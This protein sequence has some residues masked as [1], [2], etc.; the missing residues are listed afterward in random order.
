M[1]H[2]SDGDFD[3]YVSAMSAR[4]RTLTAQTPHVFMTDA[5]DLFEVY[6]THIAP[7]RRQHYTC[8][9]CRHFVR[10]F[11]SLVHIGPDGR[12][13]PLLWDPEAEAGELTEAVRAM[14]R[15]VASAPVTGVL[16][17]DERAWG[18]PTSPKT[19][20]KLSNSP[21]QDSGEWTHFALHDAHV[22]RPPLGKTC[23]Q[24]AAELREDYG[25]L[26]R[27]LADFDEGVVA[28]AVTLLEQDALYRS[29]KVLG[30]A[31]WLAGLHRDRKVARGPRERDNLVWLAVATAPAGFA[32]AR[33]TMIGT[34]LEDLA[35]GLAFEEVRRRFAAK[36]HPL[37]YQRPQVPPRAGN[38]A[39]A[40]RL[41]AQLKTAGALERR[42]ARL[43]DVTAL[44][45]PQAPAQPAQATPGAVFGHI[46]P[47]GSAPAAAPVRSGV[48]TMTWDKFERTVLPTAERI[49][50]RVP[51]GPASFAALV[52]AARPEA[53]PILQWDSEE[54]RCP[55]SWYLYSG[56]THASR[57][58]LR[59]DAW[60]PVTAVARGPHQ[61]RDPDAFAHHGKRA[62]LILEGCHDT[63][64]LRSGGFFPENLRSEYHGVRATLEAYAL[65]ARIAGRD[66][67]TACGLWLESGQ[68][69]GQWGHRLRVHSRGV[70]SDFVLDRWD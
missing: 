62:I 50:L 26:Q 54:H 5:G 55:V 39:Q 15:V 2:P 35:A 27:S 36:M 42:F 61:W 19:G 52:T 12:Q 9:A 44:W 30:I 38:I 59:A 11:G 51:T 14:A 43:E 56:G 4:Y 18:T 21:W 48:Q 25:V 58:G 17:C 65:S 8:N 66:E 45:R 22:T 53:P 7:E 70:V 60:V 68:G 28:Q 24:R 32:H 20:D 34:L 1:T 3:R 47:R 16:I 41:V 6:L 31:Q 67:A 23:G 29:E 64:H 63:T 69:R 33:N 40:E 10:R 37:Q 49:E 57:W 46:A 13:V